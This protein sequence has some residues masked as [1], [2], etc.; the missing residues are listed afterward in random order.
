MA[1]SQEKLNP[2]EGFKLL[3][4]SAPVTQ[5]EAGGPWQ[6]A[7]YV[8]VH[9]ILRDHETFSSQVS[10]WPPEERGAPSM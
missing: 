1:E 8:D 2:Y 10:I 5:L 6:V 9:A 4:D 7:R 3:R